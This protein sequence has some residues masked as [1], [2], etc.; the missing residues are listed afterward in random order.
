MMVSTMSEAGN[1]GILLGRGRVIR[2]EVFSE[3][4]LEDQM[5]P[6]ADGA[7]SLCPF[8]IG[9]ISSVS[10]RELFLKIHLAYLD[11]FPFFPYG[12]SRFFYV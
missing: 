5:S 1:F 12:V 6:R 11:L 9:C 7:Q 3:I 10:R 8:P 2:G 4:K